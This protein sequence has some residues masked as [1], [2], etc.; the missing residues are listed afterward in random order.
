MENLAIVVDVEEPFVPAVELFAEAD[1]C[2]VVELAFLFMS[3]SAGV[4]VDD[5]GMN[6]FQMI[7]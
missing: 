4:D 2:V 3:F 5:I 6:C 1:D 7:M